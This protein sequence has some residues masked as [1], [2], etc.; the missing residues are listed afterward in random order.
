MKKIQVLLVAILVAV[1]TV[2][3]VQVHAEKAPGLNRTFFTCYKNSGANKFG[4][5]AYKS[6]QL[7]THWMVGSVVLSA[8]EL[9]E[10]EAEDICRGKSKG[11]GVKIISK[12]GNFNLAE[13]KYRYAY[14]LEFDAGDVTLAT[15]DLRNEAWIMV[16]DKRTEGQ[17]LGEGLSTDDESL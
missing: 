14:I 6:K 13:G 17:P 16:L 9:D 1:V 8:V 4:S 3:Q 10:S 15:Y 7:Y 5:E 11:S 12:D 2:G